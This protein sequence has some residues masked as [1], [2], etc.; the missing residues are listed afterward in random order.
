MASSSC[1]CR[2]TPRHLSWLEPRQG[3]IWAVIGAR[4]GALSWIHR[5]ITIKNLVCSV[6]WM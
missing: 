3:A 6:T 1:F 5:T 4:P 2:P